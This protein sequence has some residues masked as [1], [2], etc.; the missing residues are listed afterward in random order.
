MT[1]WAADAFARL[2]LSI[3]ETW[4]STPGPVQT[5]IIAAF[6]A[7]IGAFLTSRSQGK[8]RLIEE[9]RAI[10]A[11]Y[12][13]CFSIGNKALAIKRQHIRPMKAKFDGDTSAYDAWMENPTGP[14]SLDLD[15]R[16]LSRLR[17]AGATLERVVF[18]KCSLGHKGLAAV[19]SLEDA[20]DDLNS[21]IDYRNNLIF[22]FQ[23]NTPQ[24]HKEK[25]ALYVGAY[26]DEKVDLRFANNIA[27]LL[28]QADDC[29]FFGML[30]SLELYRFERKL[31]ARN[32]WKYRLEVPRQYPADWTLA[33]TENLIPDGSQYTDWLR[34]FKRP[35]S[36]WERV[37]QRLFFFVG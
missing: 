25:I 34:G 23:K 1:A 16:N 22:D 28:H 31:R 32:W 10:H 18:E 4:S 8:R 13:I 26:S 20:T 24:T 21:S 35:P 29:I 17:F 2:S 6:G 14:L 15:L 3:G 27:A 7:L 5:I 12:T 19:L 37:R 36:V 30:L 33:R 11:A 9:L